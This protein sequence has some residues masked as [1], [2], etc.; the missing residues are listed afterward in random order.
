MSTTYSNGNGHE[1]RDPDRIEN[2]V[3]EARARLSMTLD[4]IRERMSPGQILDQV[5]D[6]S[7]ESGGGMF[8][9]NLGRSVRDNPLPVLLI[10]A[11]I[12]WLLTADRFGHRSTF[13]MG[14][15]GG[16]DR[17]G[18]LGSVAPYGVD[19]SGSSSRE[20]I[21]SR[22]SGMASGVGHAASSAGASASHAYSSATDRVSSAAS[23]TASAVSGAAERA[24]SAVS[25]VGER[26]SSAFSG[27]RD[28]VSSAYGGVSSGAS[29][30]GSGIRDA[31]YA[32]GNRASAFGSHAADLGSHARQSFGRVID[33]Q[34]LILGAIGLAVGAALGALLPSTR[35]EDRMMGD[36][37]DRLK[38]EGYAAARDYGEQARAVASET[39]SEVNQT[40][41][42]RGLNTQNLTEAAGAVAD[43][44]KSKAESVAGQAGVSTS[45]SSGRSSGAGSSAGGSG[46]STVSSGAAGSSSGLGS[47]GSS[48]MASGVGSSSTGT[49]LH[50]GS[51]GMQAGGRP[52][53]TSGSSPASGSGVTPKPQDAAGGAKSDK[54]SA[55]VKPA[56][57]T[58]PPNAT[59][60]TKRGNPTDRT[61]S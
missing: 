60:D 21:G 17:D 22:V 13:P 46:A 18:G 39:L 55:Y 30:V 15:A 56:V 51:S 1:N 53:P 14:H 47:T 48:S 9:K 8:A 4:Q 7:K 27:A 5:L 2:E 52:D 49:G 25:S 40:L 58:T 59:T 24:A 57:G 41:D 3:E 23:R 16:T 11:G 26:A 20:G 38:D 37:A 6:Y 10:G 19:T 12:S 32:A 29:H 61:P 43:R 35:T 45:G 28:G 50:G 33:D 31:A 54:D 44:L 36:T 34:P 42:E